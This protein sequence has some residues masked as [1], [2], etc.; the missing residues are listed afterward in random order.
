MIKELIEGWS[1]QMNANTICYED[2]EANYV[3]LPKMEEAPFGDL[4]PVI[5]KISQ[6]E[7]VIQQMS[8]FVKSLTI[9]QQKQLVICWRDEF[10]GQHDEVLATTVPFVIEDTE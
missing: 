2:H 7:L 4:I 5:F 10:I 3:V 1:I 6:G 8:H 9:N